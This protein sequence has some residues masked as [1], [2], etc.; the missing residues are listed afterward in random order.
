MTELN[1]KVVIQE[2]KQQ[3]KMQH[4]SVS[5]EKIAYDEFCLVNLPMVTGKQYRCEWRKFLDITKKEEKWEETDFLKYFRHLR[6]NQKLKGTTLWV[7]Y[8]YLDGMYSRLVGSTLKQDFPRIKNLVKDYQKNETVRKAK[9]LTKDHIESFLAMDLPERYWLVRKA[10]VAIAFCGSLGMEAVRS[11]LFENLDYRE[12][13]IFIDFKVV[14]KQKRAVECQVFVPFSK[15]SDVCF[16]NCVVSYVK[17]IENDLGV[18]LIQRGP[19]FKGTNGF[20]GKIFMKTPMGRNLLSSIPKNVASKLNLPDWNA[21][22]A[23]S[24]RT[25]AATGHGAL[26]STNHCRCTLPIAGM[27]NVPSSSAQKKKVEGLLKDNGNRSPSLIGNQSSES[28]PH[29]SEKGTPQTIK[30]AGT[31]R[32][33]PSGAG[34]SNPN[35]NLKIS[36]L[37]ISSRMVEREHTIVCNKA[38][39]RN[40]KKYPF[41][42][43]INGTIDYI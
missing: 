4:E 8:V 38:I 20:R 17:A 39:E 28:T 12:D 37:S 31:C 25:T 32:I 16:G 5:K 42:I 35:R 14:N 22:T 40:K 10:V 7:R 43:N 34:E 29:F 1:E 24:V 13:G 36:N 9:V 30:T 3:P 19:L 6:M 2:L 23:N 27:K 33:A 15:N 18:D 26:E 21:Y 41:V 11:I